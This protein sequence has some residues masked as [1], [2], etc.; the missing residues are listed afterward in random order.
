MFC[1]MMRSILKDLTIKFAF[2]STGTKEYPRYFKL[3]DFTPEV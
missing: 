1:N 3:M 2:T